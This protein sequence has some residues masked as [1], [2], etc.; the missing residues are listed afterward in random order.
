MTELKQPIKIYACKLKDKEKLAESQSGGAFTAI[1]EEVL[2][3]GGNVYG[4]GLSEDNLAIYKC[5][6]NIDDLIQIKGSKYVQAK[7]G[8]AYKQISVDLESGKKVLF[9]GTPCYVMAVKNFFEKN[10]N[11]ENLY[12]VDLICHGVPSPKAYREY[13]KYLENK[14]GSSVLQFVF[15]DKNKG[16][17]H[18][19]IEKITYENGKV[20]YSEDFAQLF[21][22]HYILR[23]SC[24]VCRFTS[25]K[26]CSDFTVGDFWGI[27]KSCPELDD[28]KGCSLMFVNN[29]KALRLFEKFSVVLDFQEISENEAVQQPNL[30]APSQIPQKEIFWK[31]FNNFGMSYWLS[32]GNIIY[33]IR[34]KINSI[35]KRLIKYD[36]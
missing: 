28:N 20:E 35:I 2:K 4:C 5:I 26:R 36:K 10:K 33:R 23:D 1:A 34:N 19:H 11:Y 22:T 3:D 25:V 29:E 9:S 16:G 30:K 15:R 32:V 24:G 12:T 21:Y 18:S 13:L 27:E 6:T 17:W 7:L 8:D 14:N 31:L